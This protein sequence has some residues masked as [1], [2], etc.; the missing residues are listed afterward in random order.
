MPVYKAIVY[1]HDDLQAIDGD[2]SF[3][4]HVSTSGTSDDAWELANEIAEALVGTV[5]PDNIH[6]VRVAISNPDVI[7]GNQSRPVAL[8]GVRTT[9][10]SA[11]PSWNTVKFQGRA[12]FVTRP[13]IWHIRCGLTEDDVTGQN[14][15]PDVLTAFGALET[16]FNLLTG[17]CDVNGSTYTDFSADELVRN[18]QQGWH[19][20]TRPGFKRGY[21]PV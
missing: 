14:L 1:F 16:A 17:L 12:S 3:N 15:V 5:M 6:A 7:N 10:G 13:S 2:F 11:L 8:D 9:T 4:A 20:R 21:V 19:R 18:R